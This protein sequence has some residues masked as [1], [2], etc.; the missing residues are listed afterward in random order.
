MHQASVSHARVSRVDSVVCGLPGQGAISCGEEASEAWTGEQIKK[1]AQ[2]A[3]VRAL[4][5]ARNAIACLGESKQ[6]Q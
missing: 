1:T 6:G 5:N 3:V 2:I 4:G